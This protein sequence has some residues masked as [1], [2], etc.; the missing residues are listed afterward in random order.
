MV[1]AFFNL[2]R[3]FRT[4]ALAAGAVLV[5]GATPPALAQQSADEDH[6][7]KWFVQISA[8]FTLEVA[9]QE[10]E[11]MRDLHPDV[12]GEETAEMM[13]FRHGSFGPRK[14]V[15]ISVPRETRAEAEA[16]C[17]DLKA[18]GGSCL[19]IRR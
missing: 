7:K 11:R 13:D 12:L 4:A 19:V 14:R 18:D 1:V 8:H 9:E 5:L 16:L 6:A 3:R 2:L 10:W 15:A 17:D